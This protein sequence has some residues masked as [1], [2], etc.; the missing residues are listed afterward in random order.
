LFAVATNGSIVFAG[1]S[2]RAC[3]IATSSLLR[4]SDTFKFCFATNSSS[5]AFAS[6]NF[7]NAGVSSASCF[8][9]SA[10]TSSLYLTSNV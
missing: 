3:S 7:A 4:I 9:E 10:A 1:N 8:R 6:F 5:W 2:K